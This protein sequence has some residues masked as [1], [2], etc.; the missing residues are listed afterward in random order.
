MRSSV[1]SV[2][3][4]SQPPAHCALLLRALADPLSLGHLGPAEW[5]LLVRV[6]RRARLHGILHARL[7]ARDAICA[8]PDRALAHL[9]SGAAVARYRLQ[10][11]L[12]EQHH[13]ARVLAPLGAPLVL[14]KGG[15]YAA[16]ELP[17]A[18]GRP[19]NDLDFMVPAAQLERVETTLRQ[20]GWHSEVDDPYDE[21]YYREWSHEVPPLIGPGRALEV[22]LHHTI[23]PPTSRLRPDAARLFAD[24][25]PLPG[26]PFRVLA[27]VDQVLHAAVHLMQDIDTSERFRD[28]VDIDGLLRCFGARP[29]FAAD[30]LAHAAH[31]GLQRPLWYA[32]HFAR[33]WLDT[34]L[35]TGL[36][37]CLE[38][39]APREPARTCMH[40]LITATVF[41]MHPDRGRT[42]TRYLAWQLLRMRA[43]WM[44]MP[45]WLL[46]R[47]VASKLGRKLRMQRQAT[48]TAG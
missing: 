45:A 30:L 48:S 4:L 32:V 1:R 40:V 2:S 9:E 3:G 21:R 31:H 19:L 20:A 11:A 42:P 18:V 46:V 15:A 29:R 22:D 28:L 41:P 44:R 10:L 33:E 26:S 24:A 37:R 36:L 38:E 43:M 35:D 16:Q 17:F 6:A 13:L 25:K 14:L 23:L 47:H 7:A 5:D 34:P 27:P 8:V 39:C 12:L